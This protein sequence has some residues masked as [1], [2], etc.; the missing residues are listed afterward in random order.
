MLEIRFDF[1]DIN[2]F[3][4]PCDRVHTLDSSSMSISICISEWVFKSHFF[5]QKMVIKNMPLE[6]DGACSVPK[7]ST[8]L[9][10]AVCTYYGIDSGRS[11]TCLG[12][13]DYIY[14][15]YFY[16]DFIHWYLRSWEPHDLC[17][18][19][20]NNEYKGFS[21]VL[22]VILLSHHIECFLGFRDVKWNG[23]TVYCCCKCT[24]HVSTFEY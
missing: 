3:R 1:F 5:P 24:S 16:L 23:E 4:T 10:I 17:S 9:N 6:V 2:Q 12:S 20:V 21:H 22:F 7:Q 18:K 13:H 15:L 8:N 19:P 14:L 11:S